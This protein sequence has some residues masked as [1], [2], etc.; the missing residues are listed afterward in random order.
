MSEER[1]KKALT[2][3]SEEVDKIIAYDETSPEVP[4]VLDAIA[5]ICQH[6]ADVRT[7]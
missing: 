6:G 5:A 2:A 4:C 7:N 1:Y 3:I